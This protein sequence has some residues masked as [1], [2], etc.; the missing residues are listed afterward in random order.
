MDTGIFI[1]AGLGILTS[2]ASGWTSWFFARKKYD[3]EVDKTIIQ[4]MQSSL[5][6]YKQLSDD[7]K[8]RLQEVLERNQA[9]EEEVRELR[10]EVRA[11]MLH[12]YKELT[13]GPN[14]SSRST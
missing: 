6:F 13:S 14:I 5:E 7:N 10:K 9:L 8:S 11:L 2:I 3:S 12:S 4:N 1:T